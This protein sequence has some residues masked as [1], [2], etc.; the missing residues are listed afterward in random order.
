MKW[1]LDLLIETE[2][3]FSPILIFI[4]RGAHF[5]KKTGHSGPLWETSEQCDS[6]IPII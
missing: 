1:C 2:A 4:L 3:G 5:L 6:A